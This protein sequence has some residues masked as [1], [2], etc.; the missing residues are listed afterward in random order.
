MALDALVDEGALP[1]SRRCSTRRAGTTRAVKVRDTLL[2][3]TVDDGTFRRQAATSSTTRTRVF[4]IWYNQALFDKNGWTAPKTFDE[5]F[6]LRRQIKAAG[7]APFAFAGKYPYYMRWAIMRWIWQ[8]GGKAAVD[9]H[10]QP[11][12]RAPGR[13]PEVRPPSMADREAG[14]KDGYTLPELER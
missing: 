4:G 6:T 13:P 8:S 12:G 9:R 1:T 3:G 5:F 2:P 10:R 14:D 11:Q 7:I